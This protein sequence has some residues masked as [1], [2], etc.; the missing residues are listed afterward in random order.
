[1]NKAYRNVAAVF[2]AVAGLVVMQP[3][4]QAQQPFAFTNGNLMIGFRKLPPFSETYELIVNAGPAGNY[5]GLA[6]NT[7][8]PIAQF[9]AS[10]L[11]TCFP[12]GLNDLNWSAFGAAR[13]FDVTNAGIDYPAPSVW[14][15]KKRINAQTQSSPYVRISD[16]GLTGPVGRIASSGNNAHTESLLST[17]NAANTTTTV[18]QAPGDSYG[19]SVQMGPNGNLNGTFGTD[20]ENVTPDSFT[21]TSVSDLYLIV[22]TDYDD[23]VSGTTAG[24]ADYL[25]YFTLDSSGSLTF[26][27]AGASAPPP[28]PPPPVLSIQNLAGTL[29][30]SFTTTNGANYQVYFTNAA[31]LSS[32]VT[33]WALLGGSVPGNGSTESEPD[34]ATASSRFYRVVAH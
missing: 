17:A 18:L 2:V 14:V 11:A 20:I 31:G 32:P 5:T 4:A 1:M 13:V 23:P 27:A 22:P 15:T 9:T 12:E 16:G 25:G 34:T 28:P 19:F 10:Q 30:V 24:N 8:V 6:P 29:T 26:T 7:S 3:A 21:T 33:N